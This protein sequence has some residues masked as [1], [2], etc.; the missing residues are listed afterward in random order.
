VSRRLQP[1]DDVGRFQGDGGSTIVEA[2]LIAPL[3]FFVICAV[4]EYG[5][6]FRDSL[7]MTDAVN[8][9]VRTVSIM[10][11]NPDAA[12]NTADFYLLNTIRQD[13][14]SVPLT[15]I[16]RVVVFGAN[17]PSYGTALSQ[18][19]TVC[20]TGNG[21][22]SGASKCNLYLPATAFYAAQQSNS[23]F[24]KC[25]TAGDTACGYNPASTTVR[26]NAPT[27][28]IGWIGVYIKFKHTMIT[29][30]FG[31]NRTIEQAAITKFEPGQS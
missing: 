18:V 19:P 15:G 13:V 31:S 14:G 24:F 9:G 7:T 30:L 28:S 11:P 12:G 5:L 1:I 8:D 27:A 6:Y 25:V 22:T 16:D 29:G 26:V 17:D 23:N 2:S 21:D 4:F 10:G 3:L 20:K